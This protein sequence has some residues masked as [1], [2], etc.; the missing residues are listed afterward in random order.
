MSTQSRLTATPGTC[1]NGGTWMQGLCHCPLGFSGDHCELQEIRCQNG[2]KWDGLKC[3]C[4]STIY[5]SRCEFAVEQVDLDTVDAEVG[6]EVSVDQEFSPDL[7][8]NTS[9]A[10]KDFSDTFRDQMQKIYQNVQGF[11]DVEILSLRSGSIVV[12]YVVLLELPFSLQLES[13]YEKVKTVLKEELQNLSHKEDSSQ[14]NQSEP[15]LEGGV[16]A[17]ATS[18]DRSLWAGVPALGSFQQI[19]RGGSLQPTGSRMGL[20]R[21]LPEPGCGKD[22]LTVL[23]QVFRMTE[24]PCLLG[25]N[26]GDK[27]SLS[28]QPLHIPP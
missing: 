20:R 26:E 11:K 25:G 14:N 6:M 24:D 9:K 5:G 15:K 12:D 4:P 18:F 28:L 8:D 21:G 22:P 2:D 13:E 17:S 7:N 16:R 3:H 19:G 27:R 23:L 1:D 10:Y